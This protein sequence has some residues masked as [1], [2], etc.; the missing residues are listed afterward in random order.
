MIVREVM[1]KNAVKY[2]ENDSI[3]KVASAVTERDVEGGLVYNELD[4][5]VGWFTYKE[6]LKGIIQDY[7][8]LN[9]ICIRDYLLIEENSAIKNLDFTTYGLFPVLNVEE[10]ITGFI[11]RGVY[12]KAVARLSQIEKNI[13]PLR[14]LI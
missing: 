5:L 6:L 11:T 14:R 13:F 10:K 1:K 12:L 7:T 2:Y 8:V 4:E 3:L 9:E